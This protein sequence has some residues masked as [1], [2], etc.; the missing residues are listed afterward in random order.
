MQSQSESSNSIVRFNTC[1][2]QYQNHVICYGINK[3]CTGIC[4]K[5]FKFEVL[6]FCYK[7]H[8]QTAFISFGMS[9]F[10]MII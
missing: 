1:I 4:S 3:A 2:F 7:W 5:C 8:Y 6:L 10:M 9:K